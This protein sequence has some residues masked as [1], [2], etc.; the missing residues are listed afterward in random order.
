MATEEPMERNWAILNV[1]QTIVANRGITNP[2]IFDEAASD[3]L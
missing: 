3:E 1:G 2:G